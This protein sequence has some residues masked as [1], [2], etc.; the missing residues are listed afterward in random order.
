[1]GSLLLWLLLGLLLGPTLVGLLC[2]GCA[3]AGAG[4]WACGHGVHVSR[5]A[6]LVVKYVGV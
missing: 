1:V 5:E 6:A 2:C 3:A 4:A